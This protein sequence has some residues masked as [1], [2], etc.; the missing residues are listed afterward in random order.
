MVIHGQNLMC[1]AGK[2]ISMATFV[3]V[4]GGTMSTDTWNRLTRRNQYPP[5]GQLGARYW[6]GTVA[7][8]ASHGHT[9]FAPTLPDE[10]THTPADHI[11][12]VVNLIERQDLRSVILVGHSYGGLV[13]TGAAAQ[14]PGRIRRLVYLD[15]AVPDPGQSLFDL[16]SASGADPLAFAGLE[17]AL[18]YTGKIQFD[19]R[20]IRRLKKTYIRCTKSEFAGIT[21]IVK[22]KIE[23]DPDGWTYLELPT[24][25]VPMATMTERFFRLMSGFAQ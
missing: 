18:A 14:V 6:D 25:H 17:A 2:I 16:F 7:Y 15:A 3:L 22:Q 19:P 11:R 21:R 1:P 8:L 13:I 9:V 4:H 10:H 24:S 5:G 23:A 12:L 20:K